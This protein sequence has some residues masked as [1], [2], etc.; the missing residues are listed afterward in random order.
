M[1]HCL[2]CG[3]SLVGQQVVA[4]PE[5]P[6]E[7]G[8]EIPRDEDHPLYDEEIGYVDCPGC[9]REIPITPRQFHEVPEVL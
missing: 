4:M 6:A 3:E 1:N 7:P 2:R 9:E 8:D 5:G